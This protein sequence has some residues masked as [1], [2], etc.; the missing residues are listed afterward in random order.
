MTNDAIDSTSQIF[1]P[2]KSSYLPNLPTSQI[3]LPLG[4]STAAYQVSE[5]QGRDGRMIRGRMMVVC[6]GIADSR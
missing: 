4:V 6:A 5:T 1:L 3:F 2:P